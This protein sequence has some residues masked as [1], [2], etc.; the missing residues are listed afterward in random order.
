MTTLMDLSVDLRVKGGMEMMTSLKNVEGA[1]K[2]AAAAITRSMSAT[3]E[4]ARVVWQ[5]STKHVQAQQQVAAATK[6]TTATMDQ[7]RA[8]TDALRMRVG[9]G[10]IAMAGAFEMMARQG[11]VTGESLRQLVVQ[12]SLLAGMYGPQGAIVGAVGVAGVAL[13]SFFT[14][15]TTQAEALRKKNEEVVATIRKMGVEQAATFATEA[16]AELR[17]TQAGI[18]RLR[19][20]G[21]TV[22]VSTPGGGSKTLNSNDRAIADLEARMIVLRDQHRLAMDR[23]NVSAWRLSETNAN[24]A[25]ITR[26]QADAEER[27]REGLAEDKRAMDQLLAHADRRIAALPDVMVTPDLGSYRPMPTP[28]VKPD[29]DLEKETAKGIAAARET[30]MEAE[31][32]FHEMLDNIIVTGF[33]NAI[34]AAFASAFSGKG[35]AGIFS[36]FASTMMASLGQAITMIGAKLL[37]LGGILTAFENAFKSMGPFGGPAALLAGAALLALAGTMGASGGGASSGGAGGYGGRQAPGVTTYALSPQARAAT[38]N[39]KARESTQ[40][41]ITNIGKP[42][43]SDVR[44]LVN[45]VADGVQQRGMRRRA[46][47]VAGA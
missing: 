47:G 26:Q 44:T 11:K 2:Q 29:T 21:R 34:Q 38:A 23:A 41:Y 39:A 46:F 28:T 22:V 33:S 42:S 30:L 20:S 45:A 8:A 43:P 6:A 1:G 3:T 40:V 4:Q 5:T 10:A 32:Q 19:S 27:R 16:F 14:R 13:W 7:Q 36:S 37:Q 9:M 18:D 31:R 24:A 35:L 25:R 17:A 12:G 15:A